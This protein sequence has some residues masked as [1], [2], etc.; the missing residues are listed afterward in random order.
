[1]LTAPT[2]T[3]TLLFTDI[4]GSTQLLRRLGDRYPG[5]LA[6]HHTILRATLAKHGGYEVSTDG[7]AFFVTFSRA[8]D[9]IAAA[10]CAQ[11]EFAQHSWPENASLSVRMALHT[12]EPGCSGKDY[13]GL[14]IHRA[15]RIRDAAHG[16][17]ILISAA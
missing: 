11:R 8:T 13:T 9:G 4:Q 7:D 12:G 16:G 3:V 14:D 5:I 15:A 6:E 1:M 2:G 10:A 17:Q